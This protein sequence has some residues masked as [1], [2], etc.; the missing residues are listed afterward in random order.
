MDCWRQSPK[1]EVFFHF[2]WLG[3][4]D[5]TWTPSGSLQQRTLVSSIRPATCAREG[6]APDRAGQAKTSE[7]N[8]SRVFVSLS[9]PQTYRVTPVAKKYAV[10]CGPF[11]VTQSIPDPN[12]VDAL[13]SFLPH[14]GISWEQSQVRSKFTALSCSQCSFWEEERGLDIAKYTQD[15]QHQ[16]IRCLSLTQ[17]FIW[18]H[19]KR[20]VPI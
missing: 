19:E 10:R 16:N 11:K 7:M 1:G 6:H 12:S 2:V 9:L 8:F 5:L 15:Y 3:L 13:S 17:C 4:S 14:V 20:V 18:K